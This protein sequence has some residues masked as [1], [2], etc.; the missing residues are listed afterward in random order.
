MGKQNKP[1]KQ[2]DFIIYTGKEGKVNVE[3]FLKD[4]TVWL[5]QKAI[6]ILFGKSKAT[7]SEHLT[8]IFKTGE[9]D[10]DSVVRNF[11]TTA[12]DGKTYKT[13]FYNLDAIISDGYRVNSYQTTQF[14]IWATKTL[15]E[16]IIKGF[17]FNM[18]EPPKNRWLFDELAGFAPASLIQRFSTGP[19]QLLRQLV[20]KFKPFNIRLKEL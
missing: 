12:A 10:E 4:E 19:M 9:L 8:N 17:V 1:G 16:F 5:T 6:C 13:K 20:V 15:K 18:K 3:V 11:R 7:I 14:R 2:T